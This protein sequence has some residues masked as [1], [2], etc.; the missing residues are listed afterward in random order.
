M[1]TVRVMDASSARP[2]S[3]ARFAVVFAHLGMVVGYARRHGSRDP[4]AIAAE[5]MAIA[6]R[7]LADVPADEVPPRSWRLQL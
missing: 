3:E 4:E 1:P 5:V 7:R 2:I 6:W